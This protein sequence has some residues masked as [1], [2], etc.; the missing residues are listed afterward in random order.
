M[1]CVDILHPL[2][3]GGESQSASRTNESSVCVCM[4]AYREALKELLGDGNGV[5]GRNEVTSSHSLPTVLHHGLHHLERERERY[6]PV[7]LQLS[8]PHCRPID[9]ITTLRWRSDTPLLA[10]WSNREDR[11]LLL[12]RS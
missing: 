2:M 9:S 11:M 1:L 5:R 3:D 12:W 7:R 10:S 6:T 8:R 4:C